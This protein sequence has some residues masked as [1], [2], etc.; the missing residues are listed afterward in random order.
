M[1]ELVAVQTLSEQQRSQF[2]QLMRSKR[3]SPKVAM[4]LAICLGGLGAHR[5]Y[6]KQVGA[7]VLYLAFVWTFI[8]LVLALFETSMI[9]NRVE[10]YND[11]RAFEIVQRLRSAQTGESQA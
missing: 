10:R 1:Y 4:A 6:M 7:G 11:Q 2:M 8:P 3:K 9:R 5:F